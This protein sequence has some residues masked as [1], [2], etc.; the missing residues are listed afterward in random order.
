MLRLGL[1]LTNTSDPRKTM[2]FPKFPWFKVDNPKLSFPVN[3]DVLNNVIE[4]EKNVVAEINNI[5][6][7]VSGII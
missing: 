2:Y 6:R 7:K 4:K 1:T 5:I 3:D